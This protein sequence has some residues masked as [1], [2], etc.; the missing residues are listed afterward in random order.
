MRAANLIVV[1]ALAGCAG[2]APVKPP[3]AIERV[4][5]LPGLTQQ[6][7]YDRTLIWAAEHFRSAKHVLEYQDPATATVIGNGRTPYPCSGGD[8]FARGDWEVPFTFRAEAKD[9]KMR[10]TFTNVRLWFPPVGAPFYTPSHEGEIGTQ[11]GL[12]SATEAVMKIA[13]S[14]AAAVVAETRRTDW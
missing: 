8:C 4:Y 11:G 13:D 12:D 5:D 2:M 6:Q 9:G 14:L 10:V 3:R 1:L 7:I